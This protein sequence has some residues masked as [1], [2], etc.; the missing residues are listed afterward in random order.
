MQPSL[1]SM[2]LQFDG[3]VEQHTFTT[4]T[5]KINALHATHMNGSFLI[6]KHLS[7]IKEKHLPPHKLSICFLCFDSGDNEDDDNVDTFH[8]RVINAILCN[9]TPSFCRCDIP[10]QSAHL[11]SY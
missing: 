5:H 7:V 10:S 3:S 2:G 11:Y 4:H 6:A 1:L 9:I 8:F